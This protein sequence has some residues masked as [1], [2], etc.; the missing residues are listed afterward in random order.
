MKHSVSTQTEHNRA[1]QTLGYVSAAQA[2]KK[3]HSL[4]GKLQDK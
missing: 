1:V 4:V 2:T 3:F